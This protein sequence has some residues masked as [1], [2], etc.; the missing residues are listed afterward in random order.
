MNHAELKKNILDSIKRISIV[1]D[2][3]EMSGEI[4]RETIQKAIDENDNVYIPNIGKAIVLEEPMAAD[5]GAGLPVDDSTG[6]MVVDIGGGTSEVAVLSLGD[7]V[8]AQSVRVAGD[9]LDESIINYI[10]KMHNMLIGER[11]AEEIKIAIGSTIPYEDEE[12]MEVK[13]RNL[14]DGLP[15]SIIITAAPFDTGCSFFYLL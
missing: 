5:I 3:Y 9:K 13:G 11:T 4:T 1:G 6:C 2:W 14:V 12:S 8:T 7:I 15:K 10:R